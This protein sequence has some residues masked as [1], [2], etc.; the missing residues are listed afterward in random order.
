MYLTVKHHSST[1]RRSIETFCAA[2]RFA[3]QCTSCSFTHVLGQRCLALWLCRRPEPVGWTCMQRH[4]R[5]SE[6]RRTAPYSR[7]FLLKPESDTYV[8]AL[9]LLCDGSPLLRVALVVFFC[10]LSVP[11]MMF[12]VYTKTGNRQMQ[13]GIIFTCREELFFFFWDL[14]I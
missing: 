10:E 3:A 1:H 13:K 14:L 5:R 9:R 4:H 2:R 6:D 7:T 11:T 8:L 12:Q